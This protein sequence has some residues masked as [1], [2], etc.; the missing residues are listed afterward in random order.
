LTSV[1]VVGED[2]IVFE[3]FKTDKDDD[4]VVVDLRVAFDERVDSSFS[5]VP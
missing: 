4:D 5:C 2:E 3:T 1:D